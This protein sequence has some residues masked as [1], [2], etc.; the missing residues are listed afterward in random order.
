MADDYV[1]ETLRALA[2]RTG[3]SYV[4]LSEVVGELREL[5]DD[6]LRRTEQR[7]FHSEA[8]A[9]YRVGGEAVRRLAARLAV[10]H[11]AAKCAACHAGEIHHVST[12]GKTRC[13][14]CLDTGCEYCP[15][16]P[17][18]DSPNYTPQELRDFKARGYDRRNRRG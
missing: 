6:L 9:A 16:R 8:R 3:D 11:G 13:R 10:R 12:C 4:S 15:E 14:N 17:E 18:L 2:R 1:R 7:E 5:S